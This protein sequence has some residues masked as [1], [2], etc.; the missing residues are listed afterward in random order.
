MKK[1]N[2]QSR[3]YAFGVDF[4][5]IQEAI[6]CAINEK[7]KNGVYV[8]TDSER[9]PCFDFEDYASETRSYLNLVFATSQ[10]E[11]DEKL[12]K[13]KEMNVL[14]SNYYKLTE[15]LAPMAYW[16]G[17]SDDKVLLTDNMGDC[18]WSIK[19]FFHKLFGIN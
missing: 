3:I 6:A 13:L 17:D 16:E 18:G 1:V 11:L 5:D 4:K 8:G 12:K 15:E 19:S 14:G 10:E 2:L 9:Y 7:P